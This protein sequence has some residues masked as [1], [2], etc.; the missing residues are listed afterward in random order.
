MKKSNCLFAATMLVC[1][2]TAAYASDTDLLLTKDDMQFGLSWSQYN[3]REPNFFKPTQ[4]T[5]DVKLT[6]QTYGAHG[7]KTWFVDSF[8]EGDFL[9][10]DG[11]FQWGKFDYSGSGTM[12]SEPNRIFDTRIVYG[13]DEQ[14]K[15]GVLTSY[16]GLGYRYLYDD[17]RGL[18]TTMARGYQREQ[19]YLYMP[20]GFSYKMLQGG[21]RISWNA[22][23][24]VLLAGRNTTHLSDANGAPDP[25]LQPQPPAL[26]ITNIVVPDIMSKQ[27]NGYEIRLSATIT[28]NAWEFG[29]YLQYWKINNSETKI[30]TETV[31][32]SDNK[33][34]SYTFSGREPSNT[35][36]DIGFKVDR[37]F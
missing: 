17:G 8:S 25:S 20:F 31:Q 9:R 35:T 36:V 16:I 22:E 32:T 7:E 29:P 18:T 23:A 6:G 14:M 26:K 19:Q 28:Q 11:N 27:Q 30:F 13:A 2:A 3:Y 1:N 15:S 5:H 34:T 10:L 33:W 4:G 37:H 12:D 21:K 24:G